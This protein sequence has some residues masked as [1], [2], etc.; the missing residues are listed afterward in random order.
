M[1]VKGDIIFRLGRDNIS[2]ERSLL[3]VETWKAEWSGSP[4]TSSLISAV[5][6]VTGPTAHLPTELLSE[7]RSAR[8]VRDYSFRKKDGV[9]CSG[10]ADTPLRSTDLTGAL[11]LGLGV[12]GDKEFCLIL[13]PV[14]NKGDTVY[15]RVGT[16]KYCHW[17]SNPEFLVASNPQRT[18]IL[19]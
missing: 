6:T 10:C 11:L 8:W 13:C 2:E 7:A 15:R 16:L 14:T 19:A 3:Q 1:A 9:D 5:L 12:N 17:K 4:Y 18:L